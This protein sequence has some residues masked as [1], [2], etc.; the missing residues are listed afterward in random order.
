[1]SGNSGLRVGVV[2]PSYRSR[3]TILEVI[4]K[5]GPEVSEIVVVDDACPEKTGEWVRDNCADERVE[6][7]FLETNVGVGGATVRGMEKLS[8]RVQILV[9][10]DSD[11]QMDPTQIQ[12][13]TAPIMRGEADYCKAT[14]L[15][16][17]ENFSGMPMI[18]LIGNSGLTLFSKASSGYWSVTDPTNGYIALHSQLFKSLPWGKLDKRFFFE[19]DLLFR[20]YLSGANLVEIPMNA[21]YGHEKSNLSIGKSALVFPAKHFSRLSK[22]L[23]LQYFVKE[24]N[25]GSILLLTGIFT[26]LFGITGALIIA[27]M[28]TGA[29]EPATAGQVM[30]F[31]LPIIVGYQSLL[32]F[33]AFDV[34]NFPRTPKYSNQS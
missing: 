34:G 10:L 32:S 25:P 13:L 27:F 20:C 14:R 23:F 15:T 26:L 12:L 22:R 6:I 31:A 1:M 28:G 33:L 24:W 21:I 17:R 7:E 30:L 29:D 19:S 11:G 2:I 16:Q 4:S 9:K 5:I 18:R 3:A 8:S